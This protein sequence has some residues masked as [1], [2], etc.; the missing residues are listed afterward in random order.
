LQRDHLLLQPGN[1]GLER[2]VLLPQ[3]GHVAGG[4]EQIPSGG[5]PQGNPGL[6]GCQGAQCEASRR[7][8]V[9]SQAQDQQGNGQEDEGASGE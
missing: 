2:S 6:D 8:E 4:G 9:A 7:P 5:K 3:G 1:L